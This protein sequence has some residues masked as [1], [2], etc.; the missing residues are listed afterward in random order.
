MRWV[1]YLF[2][3][4]YLSYTSDV[5]GDGTGIYDVN[6]GILACREDPY[7]REYILEI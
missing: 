2:I 4:R 1:F 5:C 3:F 7:D 6:I